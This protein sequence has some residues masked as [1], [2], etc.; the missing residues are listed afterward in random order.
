[1]TDQI[2]YTEGAG[3]TFFLSFDETSSFEKLREKADQKNLDP[4]GYILSKACDKADRDF[5]FYNK[6]GSQVDFCGNAL[7]ALG[8][9]YSKAFSEGS[10]TLF[11]PAGLLKIEVCAPDKVKAEMPKPILKEPLYY[12]LKKVAYI[13]AGVPHFIFCIEDW[14]L[15]FAD[16]ESLKRF[17]L[18]FRKEPLGGK[19]T[20]NL[21]FYSKPINEND[22]IKAITFERG[23]EDFTLACGSGALSIAQSLGGK[24]AKLQM[25]GG[26][27]SVTYEKERVFMTGPARV[28]EVFG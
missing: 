27:L 3:N 6:D 2:F 23:V 14:S 5:V 25:P 24:N 18:D 16:L 12:K 10:L 9:C 28:I 8:L 4:D 11:T 19:E 13:L 7:R 22:T 20:Y 21:S 17:C 1:M 26:L 15:D